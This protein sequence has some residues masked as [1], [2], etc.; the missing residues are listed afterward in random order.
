MRRLGTACSGREGEREI[1]NEAQSKEREHGK[2]HL[3]III[4]NI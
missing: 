4:S 2:M 3:F 1:E